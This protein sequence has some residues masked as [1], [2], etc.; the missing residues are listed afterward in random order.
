MTGVALGDGMPLWI[1]APH[2][3]LRRV[4]RPAAKLRVTA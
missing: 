1:D 2:L 3:Y 4:A